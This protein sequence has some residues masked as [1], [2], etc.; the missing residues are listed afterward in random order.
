MN[1]HP[2]KI[3]V[4]FRHPQFVHD[5][6]RDAIRNALAKVRPIAGLQPGMRTQ[7]HISGL[8]MPTGVNGGGLAQARRS[9]GGRVSAAEA[10]GHRAW[11]CARRARGRA[12]FWGRRGR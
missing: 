3:E 2:A 1:V 6:T 4:R 12:W 10:G 7:S 8:G 11:G 5:F 9:A